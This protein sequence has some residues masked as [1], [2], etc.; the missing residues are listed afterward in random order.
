MKPLAAT[1]LAALPVALLGLGPCRGIPTFLIDADL[2][3]DGVVAQADADAAGACVG[4]ELPLAPITYD[5]GG[6]PLRPPDPGACAAAD[7]DR[8]GR[9]TPGDA[10]AIA[11]RIGTPVCNGAAELCDRRFD[12]VAYATTHN[13]MSARFAPY[14]YSILGSNQCSGV[15]TQLADGIRALMLD[16]HFWFPPDGEWPDLYLC[17]ADC[18]YG[19][20][21][22]IDGL[23]EIRAFLDTHPAEVIAFII[24]TSADTNDMEHWIR[25]AFAA[26]GLLDYVHTQVPGQ[27][28][29]TLGEMIAANRRLVVLTDD[30]TPHTRCDADGIPCPWYQYLWSSLA[31]ETH[32]SYSR[33]SDFSCAD[34][35]GN[36]GNDLFILNH[37]LTNNTGAP[38]YA[39]QVNHD[40]LLSA[41]ARECWEAQGRIPN[42]VTVDFYEIGGVVRTANLLNF[43]WS[44][45]EAPGSQ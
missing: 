44:G 8:N 24:E 22:L 13:A 40:F 7:V 23:A 33:P 20:Q 45:G 28:W 12:E 3:D 25:D 1:L 30:S 36:P 16:I 43:L 6:C 4:S 34:N 35:R 14:S 5:A 21:L 17:H 42:F 9:V 31:F 2:D 19:S 18:V 38:A 32:F 15:P 27:P 10:A 26:S 37:F 39:Q 41:R 29:P 11:A